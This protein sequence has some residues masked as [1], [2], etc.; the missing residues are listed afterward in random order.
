MG[1][2]VVINNSTTNIDIL[3]TRGPIFLAGLLICIYLELFLPLNTRKTSTSSTWTRTWDVFCDAL[4]AR[5]TNTSQVLVCGDGA[6]VFILLFHH[7]HRL[8]DVIMELDVSG[9]NNWRC[10]NVHE[11]ER[12]IGPQVSEMSLFAVLW[13]RIDQT[14]LISTVVIISIP[15]MSSSIYLPCVHWLRLYNTIQSQWRDKAVRADDE[16]SVSSRCFYASEWDGIATRLCPLQVENYT[17]MFYSRK[18]TRVNDAY[19]QTLLSKI[20]K[21]T[22]KM[23]Q[24]V[25]KFVLASLPPCQAVMNKTKVSQ[26]WLIYE[27]CPFGQH[28]MLETSWAWM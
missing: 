19:L 28:H 6:D 16:W 8:C 2:A 13:F 15:G 10:I 11:L 5:F 23:S 20:Q 26:S 24:H 7:A 25:K 22:E 18:D 27:I 21:R 12:K 14:L 1:T 9:R 4:V 3:L 17:C